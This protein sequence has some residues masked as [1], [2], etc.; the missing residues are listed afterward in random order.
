[1][2]PKQVSSEIVGVVGDVRDLG[3]DQEVEPTFYSISTGPVMT[4]L[5]KT[6]AD[7]TQFASA[8]REAIQGRRSRNSDFENPAS[9]SECR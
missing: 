1:M 8:V 5:I 4:V 9:G 3:L 2:D 7:P 6:Q